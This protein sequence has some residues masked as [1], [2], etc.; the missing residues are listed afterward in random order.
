MAKSKIVSYDLCNAGKD[1]A[2]LYELLKSYPQWAKITESTW[3]ISTDKSC[4]EVRDEINS[5]TDDDDRIF[6][7]ELTGVAAWRNVICKSDY[8]KE[9][10]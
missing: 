5:V 7:A 6:V 4:V 9:H 3:F 2:K 8:L 1:Y 10:L